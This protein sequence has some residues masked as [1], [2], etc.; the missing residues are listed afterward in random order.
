M[1]PLFQ[2]LE[3]V[4]GNTLNMLENTTEE[5]ANVIPEGYRNNIRWNLGHILTIQEQLVF[6]MSGESLQI[7]EHYVSY[8][9]KDTSPADWSAEPPSLDELKSEL[10]KQ[11]ERIKST[12]ANR[13]DEEVPKPFRFRDKYEFKTVGEL[14]AF[15]LYH[16]GMHQ[17]LINGM[18]R[19]TKNG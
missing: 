18:L 10:K 8:F 4:R 2:Q 5:Q 9:A 1:N 6:Y 19:L 15:T 17:G 7:P 14:I 3:I 12:F 16:E 11:T 13:L